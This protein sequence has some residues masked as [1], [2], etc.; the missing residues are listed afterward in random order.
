MGLVP[1]PIC[2]STMA[3]CRVCPWAVCAVQ[4]KAGAVQGFSYLKR[5]SIYIYIYIHTHA[6]ICLRY[7]FQNRENTCS[8]YCSAVQFCKLYSMLMTACSSGSVDLLFCSDC[9]LFVVEA[10]SPKCDRRTYI[11]IHTHIYV[12][13]YLHYMCPL[14]CEYLFM[15]LRCIAVL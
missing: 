12:I 11:P 14:P 8:C 5:E 1:A 7:M 4:E 15:L 13:I 10:V 6:Y 2:M 3:A 9:V